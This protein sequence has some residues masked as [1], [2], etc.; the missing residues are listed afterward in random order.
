MKKSTLT[1][2]FYVCCIYTFLYLPILILIVFSFNTSKVNAVWTG[3]TFNWYSKLL[4]DKQILNALKNTLIVAFSSTLISTILGTLTAVGM[5]KFKFKGKS[6]LDGLLY[7]PVVIPEIVLGIALLAFFSVVKVSLGIPTLIIAH[8]TFCM[9]YVFIVVR[10]RIADFDSSLEEAAMDLGA[11][12]FQT[13]RYITLPIIMPGIIAGILLSLTLSM[14]D[15][16]VSFFVY[17][18]ESATLP[19]KIFSMVKT[20]V[21]PEINAL[22]TIMLMVTL[23]LALLGEKFKAKEFK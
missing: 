3:F 13:F 14:D 12:K 8:V 6:V 19:I 21:S 1:T 11:T 2:I 17:G 16:I 4:M 5:Y 9:P 10:S 18:P 15:V 22:S 7:I 23:T 20:G